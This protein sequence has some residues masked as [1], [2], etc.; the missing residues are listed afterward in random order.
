M[1]GYSR[2]IS[3]VLLHDPLA[4]L[5]GQRVPLARLHER[6]DEQVLARAPGGPPGATR[7]EYSDALRHAP[8][9]E[10][11]IAHHFMSPLW[12]EHDMELVDGVEVVAWV[13]SIRSASPR[14][15]TSENARSRW[16]V[17]EVLA[18]GQE[19]ALVLGAL[20]RV[21][22]GARPDRP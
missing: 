1:P 18:G 17:G 6:I 12:A 20:V 14:V 2:P 5:G 19:L 10:Y 4:L 15:P 9:S 13:S 7:P 11:G 3:N 21:A 22:A 16:S 8:G